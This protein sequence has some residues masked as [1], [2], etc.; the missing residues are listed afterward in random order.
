MRCSTDCNGRNQCEEVCAGE[1]VQHH[2]CPYQADCSSANS[3][4]PDG[5]EPKECKFSDWSDW[6]APIACTGLCTRKRSILQQNSCGGAACEGPLQDSQ[7]C[8]DSCP[9]TPEDCELSAWGEW[10][11]C[12]LNVTNQRERNRSVVVLPA[13]GGA[14][15]LGALLETEDCGS[16]DTESG[17][18]MLS[19]WMDW[20][21]CKACEDK[22]RGR[23]RTILHH[24]KHGGRH[25]E[26]TLSETSACPCSNTEVP[27]DCVLQ[28]WTDWSVCGTDDRERR[29]TRQIQEATDSGKACS[30]PV[31][32]VLP[33]DPASSSETPATDCAFADWADWQLCDKSCDGGQTVRTRAIATPAASGGTPCSGGLKETASCNTLSCSLYH[34]PCRPS[35]WTEWGP[36]TTTC[37]PGSS[38][39]SRTFAE[40]DLGGE[41]CSLTLAET[42]SCTAGSRQDC[43]VQDCMIDDWTDWKSCTKTCS[44]GITERHRKITQH[45]SMGGKPCNLD[46]G[47]LEEVKACGEG[48]CEVNDNCEDGQWGQWEGWTD[49]TKTCRGGFRLSQRRVVKEANYCGTPAQGVATKIESCNDGIVCSGAVDC[50]LTTWTEWSVCDKPCTGVRE[51]ARGIKVH[52]ENGGV[53]CGS[54]GQA[55]SLSEMEH[56]PPQPG[57]TCVVPEPDGCSVGDWSDWSECSATCDGG[58]KS[59]SREASA[60][61]DGSWYPCKGELKQTSPCAADACGVKEDCTYKDWTAWGNC[62]KCGGQTYRSR[63]IQSQPAY[64]G[65]ECQASETMQTKRCPRECGPHLYWCVWS[66]WAS[67]SA[68]TEDCGVGIHFRKRLLTMTDTQPANPLAVASSE[69]DCAGELV[70]IE[71]CPDLPECE[72]CVP[73]DCVLGEWSEW[74]SPRCEG[75]CTRSRGVATPSNEC[76][77][78]CEGSLNGTKPCHADCHS[79]DCQLGTWTAWTGC[80]SLLDNKYRARLITTSG[81]F[82]GKVCPLSSLNETSSCQTGAD[83]PVNCVLAAW[84]SWG[85]CSETCGAGQQSRSRSVASQASRGGQACIGSLSEL[86]RCEVEACP[87]VPANL[88][89]C[90]WGPWSV[91]QDCHGGQQVR[92]RKV[93]HPA[94]AG[95]EACEGPVEETKGCGQ[96]H[97]G[98]Q[99]CVFSL[100][101]EWSLCSKTC[102]GGQSSRSRVI[103]SHAQEDGKQCAGTLLEVKPCAMDSCADAAAT[104]CTYTDWT[105]WGTCSRSCGGGYKERS[106]D[107][108]VP[109]VTGLSGCSGTL[110]ESMACSSTP[111]Q[112]AVD[113]VWAEWDEWSECVKAPSICGVGSK[114]R[115]RSIAVMPANGG[116]LCDPRPLEQVMPVSNCQGQAPCCIDGVWQDWQAWGGCSAHR[117][118]G[119]RKRV[120]I[121]TQETFC[122]KPPAGTSTEYEECSAVDV[123]CEFGEWTPFSACSAACYGQQRSARVILRNSSGSGNPCDG[124]V[125]KA[126]RCNPAEGEDAPDSCQSH[127]ASGVQHCVMS[128]WSEW[129]SCTATCERGFSTRSRYVEV[130][131]QNGGDS[132]PTSVK[133]MK[134]CNDGVSC[135]HGRVDCVWEEWTDWSVCD[136]FDLAT[137]TRGYARHAESGGLDCSGPIREV[138]GCSSD[139]GSSCSVSWYNCSWSQ[140]SAWS[141]CSAT[142]GR[143]GVQA[144]N[145]QL[146][147]GHSSVDAPAAGLVVSR[148]GPRR[149]PGSAS[150]A[151]EHQLGPTEVVDFN[152][153]ENMN[154]QD[155]WPHDVKAYCC[156]RG[157]CEGQAAAPSTL[158]AEYLPSD[159]PVL[160]EM[161]PSD[162]VIRYDRH[163]LSSLKE[164]VRAAEA[165]HHRD[166]LLAFILG[167]GC[168]LSGLILS[169]VFSTSRSTAEVL[170]RYDAVHQIL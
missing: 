127:Q 46:E 19:T 1:Q 133:E 116:A 88:A 128:H 112:N 69:K 35:Q 7:Y 11:P 125:E 29:R 56:C 74:S 152:C 124:A 24:A 98:S 169:R 95:G 111:C 148:S 48:A 126:V 81:A 77:K 14:E 3:F 136:A 20:S 170:P 121:A 75:I 34:Q 161:S 104:M 44:G 23:L 42:K 72:S 137:R 10:S 49:C 25:C 99:D 68:C 78:P 120:R 150:I 82:G 45:A 118:T 160:E 154:W 145:R 100:W 54:E 85:P 31:V 114:R 62:T 102:G 168:L 117:G 83:A 52:P 164:Q 113:C 101:N 94:Q 26:D 157:I 37:G 17:D 110:K 153:A 27:G 155:D 166:R 141:A 53:P 30:G 58:Q 87:A 21:P 51:R 89:D 80:N 167:S 40:A 63:S 149:E 103:D 38:S 147:V 109:A 59:R 70:D 156:Q 22:Q 33:C 162:T 108:R 134:L 16:A 28:D 79:E 9:Q 71:Q 6:E 73:Q 139:G 57:E 43:G 8:L 142:C 138:K 67:W 61:A 32:E 65:A 90:Q 131:P 50:E 151:S 41:P 4:C 97:V 96:E 93:I 122:G 163:G 36:C 158:S 115:K 66:D 143:G 64:G 105:S 2:A 132:C 84:S 76:G 106:R 119:T 60:G 140:W 47:Q 159:D 135:F 12:S 18:C 13:R 15:C 107:I 146:Q 86:Q 39:R 130:N 165:R 55:T 129:T 91:W 144:R 92:T 5:E 123:D